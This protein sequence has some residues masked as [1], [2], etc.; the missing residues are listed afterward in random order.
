MVKRLFLLL[1]LMAG[2]WPALAQNQQTTTII[3]TDSQKTILTTMTAAGSQTFPIDTSIVNHALVY[4]AHP[5]ITGL[6]VTFAVSTNG[7][8]SFPTTCGSASTT[9]GAASITCTGAY[10]AGRVTL[11]GLTGSGPF[12]ATYSGTTALDLSMSGL[13]T[14]NYFAYFST[15]S[16]IAGT[17]VFQLG[18]TSGSV[19]STAANP[20]IYFD[21]T[22]QTAL[23]R[24]WNIEVSGGALNI[25]KVASTGV[26]TT[27]IAIAGTETTVSSVTIPAAASLK[28]SG[29]SQL[30][31]TADGSFSVTNAADNAYSSVTLD[32]VV[33][34]GGNAT[35][36]GDAVNTASFRRS[37]NP[38][39]VYLYETYTSLSNYTRLAI[40]ATGS[41]FAIVGE[42]AG[43]SGSNR[44]IQI[45]PQGTGVAWE[46]TT[47]GHYRPIADNT[48]ALGDGTHRVATADIVGL[49]VSTITGTSATFNGVSSFVSVGTSGT[50]GA[51]NVAG[52]IYWSGY[53]S[54]TS[55]LSG[56]VCISAQNLVEINTNAGG[57]LVSSERFKDNIIDMDHGLDWV[58]Q[59][60]P[61]SWTWKDASIQQPRMGA[62]TAEAMARIDPSLAT[63]DADGKPYSLNDRG[64][65]GVLINAVKQLDAKVISLEKRKPQ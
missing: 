36:A 25:N 58:S 7:G 16:V 52:N 59:M 49:T 63:F 35:L 1:A 13:G 11:S 60:Q 28:W 29:R 33:L 27:A 44:A 26:E 41:A 57:C 6:T 53:A 50:V 24:A 43:G 65:I 9:T 46:W 12:D 64:L 56:A 20:A 30:Y 3:Q 32:T 48:Y 42:A 18:S 14:A 45:G 61:V 19:L 34:G 37:T 21:E 5:G 8:S 47:S 10:N 62:G 4:K 17:S 2:A 40:S 39:T 51:L 23:L 55:A 54:V 22:D 31:S 38:V 15:P